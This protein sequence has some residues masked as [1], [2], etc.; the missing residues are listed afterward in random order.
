MSDEESLPEIPSLPLDDP[1]PPPFLSQAPAGGG[2]GAEEG[3]GGGRRQKK[4]IFLNGVMMKNPSYQPEHPSAPSSTSPYPSSS[5]HPAVASTSH[6]GGKATKPPILPLA[7]ISCS[8]DLRRAN[9]DKYQEEENPNEPRPPSGASSGGTKIAEDIPISLSL[10]TLQ[11]I[12]AMQLSEYQTAM[13]R[14]KEQS[15]FDGLTEHFIIYE[16][17]IGLISK[18]LL[19]QDYHLHF[20]IDDS[21]LPSPYFCSSLI[22]IVMALQDL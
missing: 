14:M 3:Q 22:S 17:P 4:Y 12:D 19:L 7:I 16:V 5:S 2:G 20:M 18:L 8:E 10:G 21:G 11:A 13:T 9:E 1:D 6:A 15:L